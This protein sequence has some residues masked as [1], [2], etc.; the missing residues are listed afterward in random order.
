MEQPKLK[1]VEPVKPHFLRLYYET[2]EIRNFD[3]SPYMNGFWYGELKDE[4]Y[5]ATVQLLPDGTGIAWANG[6]DIAPHE[7][8]DN[9]SIQPNKVTI[10]A[11]L[12][13][14]RIAKDPSVMGYTNT[15]DLFAELRR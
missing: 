11:M 9:S 15:D 3:V 6:Q 13:A 14:E 2:G 4:A 12:E 10:A 5:F 8:Y 7:L 1:K